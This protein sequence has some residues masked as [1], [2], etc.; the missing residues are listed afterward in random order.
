MLLGI[1]HVVLACVE[2][3]ATAAEVE[4]RLGLKAKG[5]GRHESLGTWNRLI[6]LGDA[7]LELVGVFD[8]DLAIGS[9]LGRPV[10]AALE[11][12][13]GVVTWAVAVDDLDETLR[14]APPDAGLVGPLDGERR[15][16]DERVVRW[17]LAHP[18]EL[19]ATAPFLIEHDRAA[20]EWTVAER[21]S[22][23]DEHHPI[24]GRA[25]LAGLEFFAASPAVAAGRLRSLLAAAV[26]PAGRAAVRVRFAAQEVR[27]VA[28]RPGSPAVIDVVVD[29]PLRT[30]VARVGDC[31]IRL[32]GLPAPARAPAQGDP[33]L[34]V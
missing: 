29:V 25:R 34:D 17:R 16:P 26:E 32:R 28:S 8:R 2:P 19:S 27:F 23:A 20:A 4:A 5:G 10:L 13:G 6:W 1:D 11:R 30:R 31:D 9:W 18:A 14:W 12:G 7:Y 22:R 21:T 33:Y 15:R 24:G 3:D